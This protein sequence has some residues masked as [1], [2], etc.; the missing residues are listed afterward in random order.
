ME[1]LT[2]WKTVTVDEANLLERLIAKLTEHEIHYCVVGGQAVGRKLEIPRRRRV[3]PIGSR[4]RDD[5]HQGAG[6]F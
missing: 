1:A 3:H 4:I 5:I 6:Q 2:F